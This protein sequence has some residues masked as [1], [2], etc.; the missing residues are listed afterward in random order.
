MVI[1]HYGACHRSTAKGDG[2]IRFPQ[3]QEKQRKEGTNA[4]G[5]GDKRLMHANGQQMLGKAQKGRFEHLAQEDPDGISVQGVRSG[6]GMVREVGH[7][8]SC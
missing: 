7:N 6:R 8:G 3:R 4:I 5:C 2:S 1:A